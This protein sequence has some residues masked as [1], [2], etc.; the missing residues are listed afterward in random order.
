M[1]RLPRPIGL[2]VLRGGKLL[3]IDDNSDPSM[4]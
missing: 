4:Q 1:T 2:A 3:A